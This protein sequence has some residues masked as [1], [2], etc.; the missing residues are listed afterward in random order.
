V[1]LSYQAS[2]RMGLRR[3]A[4]AHTALKVLGDFAAESEDP[5]VRL[6]HDT[7]EWR[8]KLI[9]SP[10]R[11]YEPDEILPEPRNESRFPAHSL[12]ERAALRNLVLATR[13][14]ATIAVA[15]QK[16]LRLDNAT[17]ITRCFAAFADAV[18]AIRSQEDETAILDR[19][20][21]SIQL[22]HEIAC[23]DPL[24]VA[25]RLEP[26]LLELGAQSVRLERILGEV[27]R[28]AN[29][30]KLARAAGIQFVVEG[31]PGG[32]T[33]RELEVVALV[34]EGLTNDEISSRLFISRSTTKVHVHR[35]LRKLD[36]K[37]R[38]QAIIRW[39]ELTD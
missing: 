32:L 5:F 11:D 17:P 31:S 1:L 2:A 20:S 16:E 21:A 26:K 39:R 3:F 33:K 22:A 30:K 15:K 24:V 9:A 8:L 28:R 13:G 7:L 18:A 35:I 25:Y 36:A 19:V 10:R 6:E 14:H 29:D 37:N 23:L 34:S 27:M 4:G 38:T 12:A